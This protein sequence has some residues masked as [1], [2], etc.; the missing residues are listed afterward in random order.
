KTFVEETGEG[1][2]S[3][4]SPAF[5]KELDL[6]IAELESGSVKGRTWEQVKKAARNSM[7][8]NGF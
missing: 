2:A 7:N 6:R 1:E 5:I 4:T 8:K 3:W